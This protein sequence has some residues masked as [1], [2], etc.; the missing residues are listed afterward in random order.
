MYSTIAEN[1]RGLS[2]PNAQTY[3]QQ[4]KNNQVRFVLSYHNA[5]ESCDL[6]HADMGEKQDLKRPQKY[7]KTD[8]QII[9]ELH[10][11][12]PPGRIRSRRHPQQEKEEDVYS[13]AHN[14]RKR[15]ESPRKRM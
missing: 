5:L 4:Q 10:N 13:S 11:P 8:E 12:K 2:I 15:K 14:K 1:F 9:N 7:Y 3:I 6:H